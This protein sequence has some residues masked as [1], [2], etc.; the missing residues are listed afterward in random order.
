MSIRAKVVAG[1]VVILLLIGVAVFIFGPVLFASIAYPLPDKYRGSIVKW[2]KEYCGD[3]TDAPNLLA[4]LIMT[5][6]GWRENARSYAGA[7]GMTQFTQSTARSTAVRLGISPF[8]PNDLI[9]NPDLSIRFGAYYICGRIRD[10]G[11]NVQK[12]LIA[13]N[14]GGGAVNAFVAGTPVKGTVA[15]A[16]KVVALQKA[17][18]NIYGRWWENPVPGSDSG[19]FTVT[20]KTD[21]SLITTVP[22]VDFWQGLLSNQDTGSSEETATDSSLNNLWR[23]FLPG[24]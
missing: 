16:S 8:T 1:S 4:G 24:Q 20:P 10:Y 23:V 13:Y 2:T 22:I 7:V 3:V 6:S 12:G 19:E 14:G 15:Y 21:V 17:Y 11:G 9:A 18:T 5:E